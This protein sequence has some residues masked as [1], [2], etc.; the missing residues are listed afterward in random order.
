MTKEELLIWRRQRGLNQGQLGNLIGMSRQ[1]IIHWER[2]R[3][4][5]PDDIELRL[6]RAAP[7][8]IKQR[9][10]RE[11]RITP[12][13]FP[14]L[15]QFERDIMRYR[16]T[17]KHPLQLARRGLLG[18]VGLSWLYANVSDCSKPRADMLETDAYAQALEDLEAGRR[19]P[20]V[21][22]VKR[23]F[24]TGAT[25]EGVE[26]TRGA[27][28]SPWPTILLTEAVA[29]WEGFN[30]AWAWPPL[31]PDARPWAI[32]RPPLPGGYYW[33]PENQMVF[34]EEADGQ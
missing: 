2:G 9:A 8:E 33:S 10:H 22:A 28:G 26:I 5:L 30:N 32:V 7:G 23:W 15:Y 3:H 21:D 17:E 11:G 14:H 1:A 4:P 34:M 25:T 24:M 16:P 6:Q 27:D 13:A 29:P 20:G 19:H 31:P 12:A 18:W